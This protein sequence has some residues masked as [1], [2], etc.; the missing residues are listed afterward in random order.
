SL[1]LSPSP[2]A[3]TASARPT[4]PTATP[5]ESASATPSAA[6]PTATPVVGTE[7]TVRAGDSL[8]AIGRAYGTT[9]EQLQAWNAGR[10]PSLATNPNII[11]PGWVLI[12]SGDPG[13]TPRPTSTAAPVTPRPTAPPS[14]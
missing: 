2:A 13:V 12:V 10:Y 5:R 9:T 8:A 3:P 7:Y 6:I 1:A 14:G 11:E 4:P